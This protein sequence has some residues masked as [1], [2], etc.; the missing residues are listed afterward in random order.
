MQP[1]TVEIDLAKSVFEVAVSRRPGA[2]SSRRRL[3]R[4]QMSRFLADREPSL[5]AMEACGTAHHWGRETEACGHRVPLLPPY[6]VRPY[7]ASQQDRSQR[8]EGD[9][10]GAPQRGES[11]LGR[12]NERVTRYR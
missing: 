5:V 10:R 3:T 11:H 4:S 2:G 6:A 7:S 12:R 9:P 8:H 1:T